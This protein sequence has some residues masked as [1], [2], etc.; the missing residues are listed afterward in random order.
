VPLAW[1][2][3]PTLA[4]SLRSRYPGIDGIT[5]GLE[6]L[7]IQHAHVAKVGGWLAGWMDGWMDGWEG[8]LFGW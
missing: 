3:D 5:K 7:V 4:L 6:A 1:E 8:G 2:V